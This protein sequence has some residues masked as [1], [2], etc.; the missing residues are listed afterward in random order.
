MKRTVLKKIHSKL[1]NKYLGLVK[2]LSADNDLKRLINSKD[3]ISF[4]IFD[5]V[6]V[7]KVLNPSDIFKIVEDLY[8]E[9]YGKLELKFAD[10]RIKAN[11]K[12]LR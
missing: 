8:T 3:I 6:I 11:L 7:R 1:H 4:D 2:T 5:T 10:I 12:Q 9:R